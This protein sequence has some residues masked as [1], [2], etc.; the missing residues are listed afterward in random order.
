MKYDV[1][2]II[3][4]GS[5]VTQLIA[6]R[7][8]ELKVY[9]EIQP[10]Q[11]VS[12]DLIKQLEPKAIILSGGPASVLDDNAPKPP[13][14]IFDIGIPILGICYGQQIM[15]KM[16]GGEIL[17][18]RGTSEFGKSMVNKVNEKTGFLNGWFL[19]DNIEQVW[20]SHGDHVSKIPDD[21]KVLA[22]SENAPFAIIA[23]IDKHFYGV[24]FHPEV[25]HTPNG[26]TLLKNFLKI[27]NVTFNW[28]MKKYRTSNI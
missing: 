4:F 23:N 20:M 28:N 8:R 1:V 21:F 15:M 24:Q 10:F 5:Q 3:D 13:K 11:N 27:A 12:N 25:V 7:L 6:R 18:G 17:S 22:K 26:L 14:K 16:L 9:C 19:N 2:L